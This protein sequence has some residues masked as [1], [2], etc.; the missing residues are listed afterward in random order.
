MIVRGA[1]APT[2]KSQREELGMNNGCLCNFLSDNWVWILIIA[3]L[4]LCCG[5][6]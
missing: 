3:L 6:N 5:C 2:A 4:I 1:I